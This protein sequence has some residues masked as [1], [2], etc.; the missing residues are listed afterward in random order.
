M[1][2]SAYWKWVE[3][4]GGMEPVEANPDLIYYIRVKREMTDEELHVLSFFSGG[5]HLNYLSPLE[6]LVLTSY[7]IENESVGE[8]AYKASKSIRH[9]YRIF[10]TLSIKLQK[11]IMER[12]NEPANRYRHSS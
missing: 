7:V 3:K 4:M 8:I 5:A 10:K 9:I 6:S 11:Y 12:K 2:D 1:P